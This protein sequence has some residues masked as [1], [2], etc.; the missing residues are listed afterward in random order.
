MEIL[1]GFIAEQGGPAEKFSGRER[2]LFT[3]QYRSQLRCAARA[4][5][6]E[7]KLFSR[8]FH[9]LRRS[10]DSFSCD[11]LSFLFFLSRST[12]DKDGLALLNFIS[13]PRL[14]HAPG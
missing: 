8:R 14:S 12:P 6:L 2:S 10:R 1:Q 3:R 13:V 4:P 11:D 9:H 5:Q 7:W